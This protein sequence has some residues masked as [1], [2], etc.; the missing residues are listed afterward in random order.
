MMDEYA[1][2]ELRQGTLVTTGWIPASA[3]KRGCRVTLLDMPAGWWTVTAV[4][5]LRTEAD[6]KEHE[7]DYKAFQV[8]TR[9]GGIDHHG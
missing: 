1:Q 6:M 5:G 7:R 9:G 3:A 2:A 4:Y 8:S